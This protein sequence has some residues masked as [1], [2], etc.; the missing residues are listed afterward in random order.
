MILDQTVTETNTILKLNTRS[1][2]EK[3]AL[4]NTGEQP[5]QV[6]IGSQPFYTMI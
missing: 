3:K 2:V 1:I 6:I 4:T 5:V